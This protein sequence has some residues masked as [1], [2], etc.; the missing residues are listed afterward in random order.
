M[1][2]SVKHSMFHTVNNR[3]GTQ[4]QKCLEERMRD[5]VE[6]RRHVGVHA[7]RRNHESKLRYG[8]IGQHLFDIILRH[9][10]SC[11]KKRRERTDES[12]H[13]HGVCIQAKQWE[14]ADGHVNPCRDHRG[15]MDHGADRSRTF[16]GIR[17]PN[18]QRPLGRLADGS[19]EK[20]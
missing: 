14:N 12:H 17:Q 9:G 16:H 1:L 6:R 3:A 20:Q 8:R 5:K 13:G 2:A 11:S 19:D 4:E 7:Q 10:D 15:G 18:V